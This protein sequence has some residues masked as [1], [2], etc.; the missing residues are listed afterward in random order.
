[1]GLVVHPTLKHLNNEKTLE[2]TIHTTNLKNLSHTTR[3]KNLKHLPRTE[4]L[5]L[6][7]HTHT[8]LNERKSHGKRIESGLLPVVRQQ[9][10]KLRVDRWGQVQR[11]DIRIALEGRKRHCRLEVP[12]HLLPV[13]DD[14]F[15]RS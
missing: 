15:I 11:G 4:T 5:S 1:H 2:T 8:Q 7:L 14:A 12:P 3:S 10:T 13:L 6:A 9:R